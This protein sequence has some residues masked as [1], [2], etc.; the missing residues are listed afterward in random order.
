MKR[1]LTPKERELCKKGIK[2]RE[3]RI[4]DYKELVD[5][6]TDTK[7]F[8]D[9]WADYLDREHA[10]EAKSRRERV[11]KIIK[12]YTALLKWEKE[13][14][15]TEKLQLKEGVEVKEKKIPTCVA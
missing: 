13:A 6:Q 7:I 3:L 5:Y 12:E 9:K 15:E 14:L 10:K 8:H 11:D 1:K 4:K 2:N